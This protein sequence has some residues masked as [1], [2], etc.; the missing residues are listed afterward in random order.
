[1]EKSAKNAM[2]D[3]FLIECGFIDFLAQPGGLCS[4]APIVE[5]AR[6]TGLI[7]QQAL[8][9]VL[10]FKRGV[11]TGDPVAQGGGVFDWQYFGGREHSVL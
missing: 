11:D 7:G 8:D 5:P 3:F 1:M 6:L 9:L 4:H 10:R 2:Q